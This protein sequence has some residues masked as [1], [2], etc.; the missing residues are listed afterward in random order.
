V[1]DLYLRRYRVIVGGVD[2]SKL[3][4]TFYIEKNIAETPNYSEVTVYNLSPETEN[5][6]Q[7]MRVANT[8]LFLTAILY[9]R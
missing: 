1:S 7:G 3:R 6:K 9:S 2:A 4:C 5:Q 8:G